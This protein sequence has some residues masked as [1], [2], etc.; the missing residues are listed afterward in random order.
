MSRTFNI[1]E[2]ITIPFSH[3]GLF[4]E[5]P[6]T[7]A[8]IWING[9]PVTEPSDFKKHK[10]VIMLFDQLE[11]NNVLEVELRGKP[12]PRITVAIFCEQSTPPQLVTVPRGLTREESKRC[13]E[14]RPVYKTV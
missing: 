13:I 14:K 1:F 9:N 3:T 11:N 7:S 12:G 5:H 10:S 6:V 8:K 2:K 4:I